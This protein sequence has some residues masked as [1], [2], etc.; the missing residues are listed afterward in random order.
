MR[1]AAA[2]FLA[3]VAAASAEVPLTVALIGKPSIANHKVELDLKSPVKDKALQKCEFCTQLSAQAITTLLNFM[4]NYGVPDSCELLCGSL[5]QADQDTCGFLCKFGGLAGFIVALSKVDK[6]LDVLYFCEELK[7]CPQGPSNA[8]V[9]LSQAIAQPSSVAVGSTIDLG[10]VIFAFNQ[11]GAST[12]QVEV[13]GTETETAL[14]PDGFTPGS[15]GVAL[16]FGI[17]NTET[18]TWS[19][20]Q[21]PF[22]VTICQGTC[23]SPYPGSINFGTVSGVFTVTETPTQA[24]LVV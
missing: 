14:V 15:Q 24:A 2:L 12:I 13:A 9:T 11:T 16:Q 7:Q 6:Y 4:L 10:A 18:F 3:G 22:N 23:G 1:L 20:G 5:P 17:Q 21:Y 19:S 8:K